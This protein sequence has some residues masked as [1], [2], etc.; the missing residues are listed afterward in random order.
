[1]SRVMVELF[2]GK[3]AHTDSL[4]CVDVPAEVARRRPEGLPHSIWQLVWHMNFWMEYEIRRLA[5]SPIPYPERAALGWPAELAPDD[6]AWR[7]EA[8]R[9]AELL[10]R[11]AALAGGS[12]E[13]LARPVPAGHPSEAQHAS[14]VEA[15]LWQT[16]VH[17]SH[18]LGQVVLVRR[19]LGAWP[20]A[21]GSDTW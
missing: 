10:G 17:N 9:F 6:G 3:H 13:E 16:L 12:P 11:L 4:A 21:S 5:G 1:M 14:S 15:V 18:H 2:H 19:A 7:Q 20:P 8:E